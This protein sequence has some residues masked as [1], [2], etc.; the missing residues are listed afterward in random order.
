MY[1]KFSFIPY[2]IFGIDIIIKSINNIKLVVLNLYNMNN[3]IFNDYDYNY[4]DYNQ[5]NNLDNNL[6]DYGWF[7]DI[8]INK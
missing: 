2:I 6:N 4:Y 8:D 3:D 5:N 1:H 7:I